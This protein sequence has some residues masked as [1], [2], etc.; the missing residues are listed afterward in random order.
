MSA[1]LMEELALLAVPSPEPVG[2]AAGA[3]AVVMVAA[4]AD[5]ST[6]RASDEGFACAGRWPGGL[7]RAGTGPDQSRDQGRDRAGTVAAPQ[8]LLH[9]L[10]PWPQP[11]A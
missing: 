7:D 9:W 8:T 11:L 2:A 6:E 10:L 5:P 3:L 4:C 1:C